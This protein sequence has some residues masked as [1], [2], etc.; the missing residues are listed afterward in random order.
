MA[1]RK[2]RMWARH[3]ISLGGLEAQGLA[4]LATMCLQK[5]KIIIL[6]I[7]LPTAV[8]VMTCLQSISRPIFRNFLRNFLYKLRKRHRTNFH[9]QTWGT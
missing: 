4:H 2:E 6:G 9:E 3:P 5:K 8:P 1:F 7:W